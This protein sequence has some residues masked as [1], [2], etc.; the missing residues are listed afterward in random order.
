MQG[1]VI[2]ASSQR[3]ELLDGAGRCLFSA[4]VSTGRAG[5]GSEPG[6][7]RTPLGRF[8][9][10]SLH[11]ENAP[12]MAVFRGRLPVGLWPDAAQGEDAILTRIITLAGLEEGNANTLSRYIY[13][14]G[15]NETDKLGTPASHGCIRLAPEAMETLF[16][17][18]C[19]GLP[20]EIRESPREEGKR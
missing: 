9:I 12:R 10:H 3:L 20:V 18:V 2:D 11:G 17:Y 8:A 7:G 1:I 5:L 19:H 16:Q 4:P 14:H 6:S 15:T 13:I